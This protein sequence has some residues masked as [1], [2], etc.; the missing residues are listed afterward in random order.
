MKVRAKILILLSSII[1]IFMAAV[2]ASIA[3]D[4]NRAIVLYDTEKEESGRV[5][6]EIVRLEGQTLRIFVYDYTYWDEM[7]TFV[8]TANEEWANENLKESM[9]TYKADVIWVYNAKLDLVYTINS[10]EDASLWKELPVGAKTIGEIFKKDNRFC[11]FFTKVPEGVMEIRGATIHPTWDEKRKTDPKGYFLVGRLLDANY[12]SQLSE[13]LGGVAP[14]I[15]Q[16]PAAARNM[17]DDIK[18]GQIHFSRALKSW[19]G[20]ITAYFEASRVSAAVLNFSRTSRQSIILVVS[21][22]AIVLVALFIFFT[23]WINTPLRKISQALEHDDPEA[24]TS[25]LSKWDEFGRVAQLID[26]FFR[27]RRTL[28]AEIERRGKVEDELSA[29]LSQ[30]RQFKD[31]AVGRELKMIELK[32]E[33]NKLSKELGR[34]EPYE[35]TF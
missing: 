9:G 20:E 25:L 7:V 14:M 4:M 32:K 33:V 3:I 19:D 26:N 8:S 11:R 35:S 16:T 31:I 18:T 24:I 34:P 28:V 12:I 22:S 30:L 1:I 23:V 21:F 29:K 2:A 6:D 5:L 27:Q 17:S 13:Y 10:R 15:S